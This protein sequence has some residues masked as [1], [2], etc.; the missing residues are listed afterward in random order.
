LVLR[1]GRIVERGSH[2]ELIDQG[3][4]Y[5]RMHDIQHG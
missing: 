1:E 4:H 5:A 3:G 2:Q